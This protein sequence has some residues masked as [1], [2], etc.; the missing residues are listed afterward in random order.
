LNLILNS[1]RFQSVFPKDFYDAYE[2]V[3][4]TAEHTEFLKKFVETAGYP[5][6]TA[7]YKD[8]TLGVSQ[9]R[10]KSKGMDHNDTTLYHVY[11]SWATSG[12][13]FDVII[14]KFELVS[15]E[16]ED[17]T[18]PESPKDYLILNVQQALYYRVNYDEENWKKIGL[19]LRSE[20]HDGIHVLNRAQIIDDLFNLARARVLKY[21]LVLETVEFLRN[22]T[23]YIPW[24]SA[25][26][27]LNWISRRMSSEADLKLFTF[28]INYLTENV[29]QHLLYS[30]A[31]QADRRIDIYNRV[32]VLTWL[33]KYG[34]EDCAKHTKKQF[35][36][37]LGNKEKGLSA[38]YRAVIYCSGVRQGSDKEFKFLIEQ[39]HAT[40][41][42]VEKLTILQGLACTKDQKLMDVGS[43]FSI[44]KAPLSQSES[45]N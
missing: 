8:K 16:K 30:S 32:N 17:F 45:E 44:K 1:S 22:E 42:Q 31:L 18:L 2:K 25:F 34:H 29:H 19:A 4:K 15:K 21:G 13:N 10:F 37:Y 6:L 7:T 11:I 38:D 36:G 43:F 9:K 40:L 14:P 12:S 23:N 41:L 24:Q 27:A 39:Y 26:T 20:N 5:L 3:M 33:C 35:A 28:Y